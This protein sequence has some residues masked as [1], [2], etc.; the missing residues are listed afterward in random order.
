LFL[1]IKVPSLPVSPRPTHIISAAESPDF[2]VIHLLAQ[3]EQ[4]GVS[5]LTLFFWAGQAKQVIDITP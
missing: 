4:A 3:Q 5:V 1:L 2:T